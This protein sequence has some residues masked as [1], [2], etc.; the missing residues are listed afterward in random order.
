M[1]SPI[2]S[3]QESRVFF[4][5]KLSDLEVSTKG[6]FEILE[7]Q[8]EPVSSSKWIFKIFDLSKFGLSLRKRWKNWLRWNL[9]CL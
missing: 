2:I 5:S 6:T 1:F 9:V 7:D 3:K 8:C 4:D